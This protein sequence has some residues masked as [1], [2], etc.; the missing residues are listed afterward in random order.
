M[1]REVSY[2]NMKAL[3]EDNENLR[4]RL[5]QLEGFQPAQV[6]DVLDSERKTRFERDLYRETLVW[7]TEVTDSNGIAERCLKVL[8]P[9]DGVCESEM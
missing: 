4:V 9:K 1:N 3:E 6:L 2:E 8:N 5:E 7:V